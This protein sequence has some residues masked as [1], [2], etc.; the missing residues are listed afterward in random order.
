MFELA[1]PLRLIRLRLMTYK[2]NGCYLPAGL[3]FGSMWHHEDSH[4]R[5]GIPEPGV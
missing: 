5:P 4:S 2:R 1:T 3:G